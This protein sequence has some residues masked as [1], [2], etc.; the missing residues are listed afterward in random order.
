MAWVYSG[1]QTATA[2]VVITAV[3]TASGT[4]T[5][6]TDQTYLVRAGDRVAVNSGA[7]IGR[8]TVTAVN[9]APDST[10]VSVTPAPASAVVAGSVVFGP[11][12]S[13]MLDNLRKHHAEVSAAI[14]AAVGSNGTSIDTSVLLDYLKNVVRPE[15][16]KI[17]RI[18]GGMFMAGQLRDV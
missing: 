7:N 13:T 12:N 9:Y 4:F 3:S 11:S 15:M 2:A 16:N 1:W 6:S 10:V 14:S 8:Y 17:E 5:L 18:M